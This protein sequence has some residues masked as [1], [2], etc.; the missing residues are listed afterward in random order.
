[1]KPTR[2]ET[3]KVAHAI[4]SAVEGNR[5]AQASIKD[6][7][8]VADKHGI[9]EAYSTSDLNFLPAF[10]S[11]VEGQFLQ[12][13]AEIPV[14]YE[15]FAR[16]FA[17]P[18]LRP[19]TF[20]WLHDDFDDQ[21]PAESAGARN[22]P[23]QNPRIPELT[24]YPTISISDLD[25]AAYGTA[26]YGARFSFSFE[27]LLN[28]QWGVFEQIPAELA[29]RARNTEEIVA[30]GAIVD[31]NGPNAGFFSDLNDN[32]I[33]GVGGEKNPVLTLENLQKAVTDLSNRK[34]K[35]RPVLVPEIVLVVP[36]AL[37]LEARRLVGLTSY[38]LTDGNKKY[39]VTN[40]VAGMSI[41]VNRYIPVLADK[42][43]GNTSWFLLPRGG[44][45]LRPSVIY[46]PLQSQQTPELRISAFT[47]N[48]LSGGAIDPRQGS[49]LND[50]I[51]FRIRQFFGAAG[52][53][54][55]ATAASNGSGK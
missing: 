33:K 45:G 41:E 30:T 1:M 6:Y 5:H 24:E 37:E 49:F 10:K 50:D 3:L 47:G 51:Q 19:Q 53:F 31:H 11:L 23:G 8:T 44:A 15:S 48:A 22:V 46:S 35:G 18:D 42:A 28:D 27:A 12:N 2:E 32:I 7:I 25:S 20:Y 52:M 34:I 16:K 4:E 38:E 40:P 43:N 13:Y 29:T 9:E 26:K 17:V 14:S 39:A 36:P 55:D 21:L 54:P